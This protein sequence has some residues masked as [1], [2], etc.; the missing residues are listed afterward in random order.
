MFGRLITALRRL[1]WTQMLGYMSLFWLFFFVFLYLTF[2]YDAVKNS[3]IAQVE[4]LGPVRVDVEK[5]VP[6]RLTGVAVR[7]VTVSKFK[8]QD[9]VLV[10]IDRARIRLHVLPLLTGKIVA[11]WDIYGYGGGIAGQTIYSKK[12]TAVAANFKGLDMARSGAEQQL[13]NYGEV[14][15]SGLLDGKVEFFV[16][17]E[18]KTKNRGL[19]R[20]EYHDLKFKVANS[21]LLSGDVPEIAFN[22]PAVVQLSMKN[23]LF[24]IDE[25]KMAGDNLEIKASGRVTLR[26]RVNQSRFN[27]KFGVKPSEKID[28]ALGMIAM[29]LP[30]PN[31]EGFYNFSLTGTPAS[32]KFKKQ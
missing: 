28:D 30:E 18:Q 4:G 5:L 15:L 14:G 16:H 8:K 2:P 21:S 23:Q 20:L 9:E 29:M 10:K 12:Q 19:V 3:L 25:W 26:D 13:R 11:D 1:N 27:L 7:N 6:Y 24:T 31:D 17:S 32:P 22:N